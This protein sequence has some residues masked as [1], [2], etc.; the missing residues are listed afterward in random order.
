MRWGLQRAFVFPPWKMMLLFP[1][2][3]H[4]LLLFFS[5]FRFA[6]DSVCLFLRHVCCCLWALYGRTL[7]LCHPSITDTSQ[8]V[9][10]I[11]G[12][13]GGIIGIPRDPKWATVKWAAP[14]NARTDIL[15]VL[16]VHQQCSLP[17]KSVRQNLLGFSQFWFL[18]PR[19]RLC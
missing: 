19:E 16:P 7:A 15:R 14:T 12:E 9:R 10:C 13:C 5:V 11:S 17:R 18:Y 8:P 3:S 2:A 4:P 1:F 6:F